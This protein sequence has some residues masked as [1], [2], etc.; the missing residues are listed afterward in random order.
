MLEI[1]LALAATVADAVGDGVLND[2][3]V[4]AARSMPRSATTRRALMPT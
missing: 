1:G 4:Q 3:A 2:D